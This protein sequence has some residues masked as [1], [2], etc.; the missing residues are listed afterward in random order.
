LFYY[1]ALNYCRN[2]KTVL[3]GIGT[4]ASMEI[5]FAQETPLKLL[6]VGLVAGCIFNKTPAGAKPPASSIILYGNADS[7]APL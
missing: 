1:L 3:L 6:A 2:A 7:F 5:G 4:G